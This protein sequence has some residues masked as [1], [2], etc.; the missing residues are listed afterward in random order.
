MPLSFSVLQNH[1]NIPQ[2]AVIV[3]AV[4]QSVTYIR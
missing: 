2:N 1:I 4:R 3:S